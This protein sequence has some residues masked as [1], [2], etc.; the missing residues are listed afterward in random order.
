MAPK[1][2]K[3]VKAMKASPKKKAMK[4]SGPSPCQKDKN[5]RQK[6]KKGVLKKK[7]FD[8]LGKLTLAEKVA[9]AAER[10][11]TADEAAQQ[12]KGMLTK[13]EHS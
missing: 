3:G 2:M 1:A 7:H 6:V 8:K 13:Q 5:S 12:L 4:S 11:E 9:K 10:A